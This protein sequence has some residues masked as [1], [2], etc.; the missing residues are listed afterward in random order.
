MRI[1]II[2]DQNKIAEAIA[3]VLKEHKH[4][5]DIVNDGLMGYEY[6][7]LSKHDLIILDIMLPGMDGYTILEKI[8]KQKIKTPVIILS[9]KREVEDKVHG[10]DLGADDYLPKPFAME[11]LISRINV[12]MRRQLNEVNI[13]DFY[14]NKDSL[15]LV[16]KDDKIELSLKEYQ[17][18]DLL[19]RNENRIISKEMFI[20]RI[21]GIDDDVE[22]NVVEVYISFLRK[23]IKLLNLP[24]QIKTIRNMGYKLERIEANV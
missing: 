1:L 21:W 5:V 7:L 17:V 9:A 19:L 10:L 13:P 12:I 22:D 20:D 24:I 15:S 8:K 4:E 23:K 3:Y 11:E 14:L 16:H 18:F 2:E 6:A